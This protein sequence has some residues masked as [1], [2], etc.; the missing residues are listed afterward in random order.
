MSNSKKKLSFIIV[1]ENPPPEKDFSL[2][3]LPGASKID[4]VARNI[5]MLFPNNHQNLDLIYYAFFTK[6]KPHVLKVN[7][8]NNQGK[9]YDEIKIASLIKEAYD[10]ILHFEIDNKLG[11]QSMQWF[12]VNDFE[13][14][15]NEFLNSEYLLYY[16]H[17]E[18]V[19]INEID[20]I[21]KSKGELVFILGGRKD[22]SDKH[23]QVLDS[24]CIEKVSLG[25]TSYL[26]STCL[27]ALI[28]KIKKLIP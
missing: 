25:P 1:I 16:L 9:I 26:A 18:G 6:N 7:S 2:K 3:N 27:L 4:V 15:L 19:N 11:N 12:N 28:H 8:L 24:L 22:L 20:K 5:L 13:S 14:F 23:E 21:L 17:E 10:N